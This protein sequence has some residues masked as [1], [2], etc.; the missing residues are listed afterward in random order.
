MKYSRKDFFKKSLF[1][2]SLPFAIDYFISFRNIHGS[3]LANKQLDFHYELEKL[4]AIEPVRVSSSEFKL[5]VEVF[6]YFNIPSNIVLRRFEINKQ[7][8]LQVVSVSIQKVEDDAAFIVGVEEFDKLILHPKSA[9]H[10]LCS[11]DKSLF[12]KC[13]IKPKLNKG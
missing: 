12:K 11:I 9:I 3:N 10:K 13:I 1:F 2:A 8:R 7:V 4:E 6:F 5:P